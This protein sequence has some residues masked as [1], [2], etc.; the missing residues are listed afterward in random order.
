MF[1]GKAAKVLFNIAI[2]NVCRLTKTLS[3]YFLSPHPN[4]AETI[5]FLK[6][7][8]P[9]IN[10]VRGLNNFLPKLYLDRMCFLN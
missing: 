3:I 10:A 5:V 8:P 6:G 7:K 4:L 2:V 1:Y 9:Y